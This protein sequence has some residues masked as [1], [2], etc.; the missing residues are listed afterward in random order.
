MTWFIA[1]KIT[2]NL[3]INFKMFSRENSEFSLKEATRVLFLILTNVLFV[4]VSSF[5]FIQSFA[6]TSR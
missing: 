5:M 1:H 2:R 3:S 4:S 6:I